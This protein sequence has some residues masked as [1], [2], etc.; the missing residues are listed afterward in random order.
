MSALLRASLRQVSVRRAS[1]PKRFMSSG[2][3]KGWHIPF[4]YNSKTVFALKLSSFLIAG[5]SI[6]FVASVYQLRKA[7][8]A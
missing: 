2:Q 7:G 1:T 5:F 3:E 4:D 8:T 6:P